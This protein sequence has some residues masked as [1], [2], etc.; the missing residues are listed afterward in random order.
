[1]KRKKE[2]KHKQGKG[3]VKQKEQNIIMKPGRKNNSQRK[4][5]MNPEN[6]HMMT[7]YAQLKT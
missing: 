1:M 7:P 6:S 3:T 5:T 4:A 2:N